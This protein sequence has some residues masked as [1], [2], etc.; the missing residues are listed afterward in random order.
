MPKTNIVGDKQCNRVFSPKKLE[1]HVNFTMGGRTKI[2]GYFTMG[3][4]TKIP[5]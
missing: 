1:L 4:R 5:G 2:P 3:G